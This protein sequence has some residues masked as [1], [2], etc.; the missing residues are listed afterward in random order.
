MSII[1]SKM[2]KYIE[3][4]LIHVYHMC[5]AIGDNSRA[6]AI[7]EFEH[8]DR[9]RHWEM[10]GQYVAD[11]VSERFVNPESHPINLEG[12]K[13]DSSS[14]RKSKPDEKLVREALEEI[15]ERF[16]LFG[17]VAEVNK[18]EMAGKS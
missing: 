8:M 6:R 5:Q 14:E 7:Y 12:T 2:I 1:T 13:Y 18:V 9:L 16:Q 4:K 10:E 11:I 3:D 15:T 17:L